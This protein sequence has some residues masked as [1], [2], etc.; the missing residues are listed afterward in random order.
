[1][2]KLN[3]NTFIKGL[4]TL[5]ILFTTPFLATAQEA[6][7]SFFERATEQDLLILFVL[8]LALVV[9][10]LVLTVA[11]Y[12][13]TVLKVIVSKDKV[14]AGVALE[15]EPSFW[16]NFNRTVTDAV[17]IE[18]ERSILLDHEYDGIRELDNHLPPWWK[19]LFYFTI[20][21]GVIYLIVYH[22]TGTMP[23]QEEEY[24]MELAEARS[25]VEARQVASTESIDESTVAFSDD[26]GHLA[27]GKKLYE[28][29]CSVC[30]QNDG[31]GLVGPNFTDK[32]WIHGGSIQD[33]FRVVKYG[34]PEKGMISWQAQLSPADMR[35]VSSYIL[36]FQGTTPTNGKE[37]QGDL[38]EPSTAPAEQGSAD[39]ESTEVQAN[40]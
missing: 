18:Q 34:V 16:D 40:N 33:L 22:V 38:Y 29:N 2:K 5:V 12:T 7:P 3:L 23:L 17:P 10:V 27:N 31:G 37:P 1:M 30:H 21:W 8:G 15:V 13:L 32:Y 25:A 14:K 26:P 35:D 6:E 19:W 39:E 28:R 9:S 24:Q 11:I 20:G 36:T 4:F